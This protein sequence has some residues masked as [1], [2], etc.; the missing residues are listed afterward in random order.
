MDTSSMAISPSK[1]GPLIPSNTIC[2]Q[3]RQ[4]K[5]KGRVWVRIHDKADLFMSENTSREDEDF[6]A[7]NN[8]LASQETF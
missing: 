3:E 5:H 8:L 6:N 2:S 1:L 7:Y 4:N